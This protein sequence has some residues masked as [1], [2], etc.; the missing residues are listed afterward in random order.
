MGIFNRICLLAL[1]VFLFIS[2]KTHYT[3]NAIILRAEAVMNSHPDSAYRLLNSIQHPEKL[4]KV[5]YV[6]W[7]LH[8]THAQYKLKKEIKSD[9]LIRIAVIYY[10]DSNLP[11]YS[12]MAYYL[13][14]CLSIKNNKNK[15]AMVALKRA[16]TILKATN[17]DRIK[18]LVD[19]NIGFIC[20]R[21]EMFNHSLNY[22]KKSMKYFI[23]SN[24]KK[25]L[26][27]AYRSISDMYNQLD[28][29]FDSILHYNDLG[30]ALAKEANDTSNYVYNLS[31]K[32]E[33]L[34]EKY[35]VNSKEYILQAYRYYH[36]K[37]YYY[38]AYLANIYSLLNQPDSAKYYLKI[39]MAEKADPKYKIICYHVGALVSK[40]LNDY[41]T[42][43]HYLEDSYTIRDSV[44]Q[45]DIKSQLYQIDK[46][47]DLTQKEKE[48]ADLKISN[49]NHVI[50]I[51]ILV[52]I[53]LITTVILLL[54]L[55]ANKRKQLTH[56]LDQQRMV[57]ELNARQKENDQKRELLLSK[58]QSRVDNTLH[59]N[60]LKLQLSRPEK[61]ETFLE[62]ITAQLIIL[63]KEWQY[64]I[65]EVDHI[66]DK[67]ISNLSVKYPQL[68]QS[69][70]IV[71]ALISLKLDISDSCSLLNMTKNTMYHRRKIIKERVGLRKEDDLEK[72]VHQIVVQT[73]TNE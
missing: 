29:P 25:S 68:T 19:F 24:D 41:K 17:E 61:Q 47:Y 66:F 57:F 53:I 2:C 70:L 49:R 51:S 60:N 54:I 56:E 18:G 21:D 14:G 40:K 30:I 43:Y 33:L 23:I 71:I 37:R 12:G 50:L 9:S 28:Y 31:R 10:K 48:N 62:E 11:K 1:I 5:D 35:P 27:Y 34:Y 69:D 3:H 46:Q 59:F 6:A 72:W 32:G 63:E 8:F 22:F 7:S 64:Y 26:A 67:R 55:V 20:Q 36:L 15:D 52:I 38:A 13:L 4:P 65:E 39:S 44:F 16:E 42:A 58:L 73:A 45:Q